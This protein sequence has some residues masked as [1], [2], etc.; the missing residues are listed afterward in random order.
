[1]V[2]LIKI[3]GFHAVGLTFCKLKSCSTCRICFKL[4]VNLNVPVICVVVL[5]SFLSVV[6]LF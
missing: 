5:C 4:N 2:K 6:L 1:M 3:A